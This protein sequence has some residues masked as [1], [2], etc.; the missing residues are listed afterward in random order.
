MV[1]QFRLE[2][3]SS[4]SP[5]LTNTTAG[6]SSRLMADAYLNRPKFPSCACGCGLQ[7]RSPKGYRRFH[8]PIFSYRQI[9]S[10]DKVMRT[11]RIRAEKALGRPLPAKAIVHHADGTKSEK[12][13]LVIC[14]DMS[15]HRLL[16]S[17][18]KIV[19][20]GGDPDMDRWCPACRKARPLGDFLV[21]KTGRA[22]GR[23]ITPC[24]PCRRVPR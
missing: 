6:R 5:A 24:R 2:S 9:R 17:R 14:Q 23:L 22:T 15:Y 4:A 10:G 3:V 8:A 16:H 7:T 11:H 20:F 13:Q 21:L 1:I 19:Q 18:M 12:S